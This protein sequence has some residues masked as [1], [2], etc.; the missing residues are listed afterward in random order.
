MSDQVGSAFGGMD[1][2]EKQ[3]LALDKRGPAK[4]RIP[5]LGQSLARPHTPF[6]CCGNQAHCLLPA[7]LKSRSTALPADGGTKLEAQ[8]FVEIHQ[9]TLQT[10]AASSGVAVHHPRLTG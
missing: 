9:Q 5:L 1:T 3:A 2:F 8:I 7:T 4:V 6:R 10:Y